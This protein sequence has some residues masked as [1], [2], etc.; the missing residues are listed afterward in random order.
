MTEATT[1]PNTTTPNAKMTMSLNGLSPKN[2][3]AEAQD[4]GHPEPDK[5]PFFPASGK[6]QVDREQERCTS[7][8]HNTKSRYLNLTHLAVSQQKNVTSILGLQKI[9][10]RTNGKLGKGR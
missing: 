4:R 1:M 10:N 2:Q 7:G 6:P 3:R 5:N 8:G 9:R